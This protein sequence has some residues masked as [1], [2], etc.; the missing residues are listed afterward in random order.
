MILR[1]LQ[2]AFE[3]CGV[4]I[5]NEGISLLFPIYGSEDGSWADISEE[6]FHNTG[7]LRWL[8]SNAEEIRI[9]LF[10]GKMIRMLFAMDLNVEQPSVYMPLSRPQTIE[11]DRQEFHK[12][13]R[14]ND[15]LSKRFEK[16]FEGVRIDDVDGL[17]KAFHDNFSKDNEPAREYH[18]AEFRRWPDLLKVCMEFQEICHFD[19]IYVEPP[20]GKISFGS[21][22]LVL[23]SL[24]PRKFTIASEGISKFNDVVRIAPALEFEVFAGNGNGDEAVLALHVNS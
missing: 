5:S 15:I 21:V 6:E 17:L 8:L 23:R 22:D 18:L 24:V 10:P 3:Y 16:A 13:L 20:D 11:E 1:E 12:L 4:E 7:P 19:E 14:E 9:T 2:N